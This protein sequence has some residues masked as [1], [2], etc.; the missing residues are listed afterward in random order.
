MAG[1][2]RDGHI[3]YAAVIF[4]STSVFSFH[5][6]QGLTYTLEIYFKY[7]TLGCLI[8]HFLNFTQTCTSISPMYVRILYKL[9]IFMVN[10]IH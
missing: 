6:L 4:C 8:T 7:I 3:F 2:R 5:T 9:V 10:Q 1:F